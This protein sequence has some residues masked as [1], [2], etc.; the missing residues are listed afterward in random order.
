[1]IFGRSS[2]KSKFQAKSGSRDGLENIFA[3]K[4]KLDK[5]ES[6]GFLGVK[7]SQKRIIS[8]LFCLHSQC[9]W[10]V[11]KRSVKVHPHMTG[12]HSQ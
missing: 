8:R 6:G 3:M 9:P 2:H 5:S 11:Q 4:K 7:K 12:S 10:N 1:M